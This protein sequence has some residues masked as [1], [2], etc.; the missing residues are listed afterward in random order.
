M[1]K[2]R[3][4][5]RRAER[6]CPWQSGTCWTAQR[7]P[8][9]ATDT[10]PPWL[11]D[12]EAKWVAHCNKGVDG[13]PCVTLRKQLD[14]MRTLS[15]QDGTAATRI[16]YAKVGTP[17]STCRVED[18]GIVVDHKAYWATARSVEE[19]RYL[20]AVLNSGTMLRLVAPLQPRA[21]PA[22]H[23]GRDALA[24][25]ALTARVTSVNVV[26]IGCRLRWPRVMRLR[27]KSGWAWSRSAAV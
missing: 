2:K 9:A 20:C 7:L 22:P 4:Q 27:W 19:A 26:G 18:P 14:P 8:T 5:P 17:M 12:A 21:P 11:R 25:S 10:S 6:R 1:C 23:A 3:S 24:A 15:Q 16:V 13:K